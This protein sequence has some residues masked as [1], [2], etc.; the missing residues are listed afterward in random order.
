MGDFQSLL[1][2]HILC[3][4]LLLRAILCDA[5]YNDSDMNH[6]LFFA[7]VHSIT[8]SHVYDGEIV[9][10]RQTLLIRSTL[11]KIKLTSN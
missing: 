8:N 10:K 9:K 11:T 7:T 5:F 1:P 6:L 3:V 2:Q 4:C